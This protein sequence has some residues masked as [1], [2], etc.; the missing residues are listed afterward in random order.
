MGA[1]YRPLLDGVPLVGAGAK[2]S[3]GVDCQGDVVEFYHFAQKATM[4]ARTVT[5]LPVE[6]ALADLE[7]GKGELPPDINPER[8]E[9]VTVESIEL[10]YYAPPAARGDMYY[11]PVYVFRVR[12]T[13]G[14]V[15]DWLISA[16][17]GST[18]EGAI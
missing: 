15:G 16:F 14:T 4:T 9:H 13:D 10:C 1:R 17:E 6:A 8:A 12:M 11:K 7:A 5:V 2:V 18:A 3:V